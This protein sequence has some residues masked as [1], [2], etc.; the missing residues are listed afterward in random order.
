MPRCPHT[1]KFPSSPTN[2][3]LCMLPSV[4]PVIRP[5]LLDGPDVGDEDSPADAEEGLQAAKL[6]THLAKV[7]REHERAKR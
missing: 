1:L 2:C 3:S 7:L 6:A 5:S 4:R